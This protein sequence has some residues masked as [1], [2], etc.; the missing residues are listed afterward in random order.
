MITYGQRDWTS[1][2]VAAALFAE[3]DDAEKAIAELRSRGFADS[4]IGVAWRDADDKGHVHT[5]GNHAAAGA[6]T[7]AVIGGVAGGV[8]GAMVGMGALLIPGV[9]PFIAGGVLASTFGA[10]AGGAIAG[11]ATGVVAGGLIGALVGMGIPKHEAEYFDEG[12]QA[13]KALVTVTAEGKAG[14]AAYILEKYGGDTGAMLYDKP[15][16]AY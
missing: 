8:L 3:R 4:N 9:G 6:G 5:E 15:S 10:T 1:R 13:G 16:G 2:S 12:L 14:E 11:A 7:G